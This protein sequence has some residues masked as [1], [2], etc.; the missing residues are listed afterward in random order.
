MDL[1]IGDGSAAG[2]SGFL[3]RAG[4]NWDTPGFGA[5]YT[6]D[7]PAKAFSTQRM[8]IHPRG[9]HILLVD[10][11]G[12]VDVFG[13]NPS[14]G[15]GPLV[16]SQFA[17]AGVGSIESVAWHP[18][19]S[20]VAFSGSSSPYIAVLPWT[21][22]GFGAAFANPAVLPG[23]DPGVGHVRW[24]RGGTAIALPTLWESG[25][26][27]TGPFV[28]KWSPAG[29]GTKYASGLGI[30]VAA[31]DIAWGVDVLFAH[32]FRTVTGQNRLYAWPWNDITGFGT[33]IEGGVGLSM[34][35]QV[36]MDVSPDG[37]YVAAA[38][39]GTGVR[40]VPWTGIA[41]GTP[42][43]DPVTLPAGIVQ[44]LAWAPDGSALAVGGT[45]TPFVQVYPWAAGAFGAK[46]ADPSSL[47]AGTV[48]A[49]GWAGASQADDRRMRQNLA[50]FLPHP[51]G[52]V[53]VL[54]PA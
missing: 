28:W 36:E 47:P 41:F 18:D 12:K 29:F 50:G 19:G 6:L 30:G 38:S 5:A 8:A 2:G 33:R 31:L 16:V 25:I 1:I 9:T 35:A 34:T 24:N 44:S 26:S 52:A 27:E 49:V 32:G 22:S 14:A 48:T 37:A 20:V 17:G 40:V 11:G 45:G 3:S 46:F 39:G 51:V 43:A 54:A 4:Y 13:W 53:T 7:D 23:G 10:A 42:V 15:L 21:G